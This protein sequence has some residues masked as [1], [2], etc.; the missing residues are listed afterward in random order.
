ML[1]FGLKGKDKIQLEGTD[2]FY[3]GWGRDNGDY[4]HLY[5]YDLEDNLLQDEI[6]TTADVTISSENTVDMDVGQH[7]R[8]LGYTDGEYKV[9]YLF[10]RKTAGDSKRT[11]LLNQEGYIHVGK[12]TTRKV[13]GKTKFFT[14]KGTKGE[15]NQTEL[16]LKELKYAIKEISPDR[17]EVK[18]DL[19]KI[20]NI[21]YIKN[22][23]SINKDMVYTPKKNVPNAGQIRFDLTD[24]NVLIFTAG[25]KERGFTDSMV[26]GELVIKGMYTYTKVEFPPTPPPPPRPLPP[27]EKKAIKK[28]LLRKKPLPVREE[29]TEVVDAPDND[30]EDIRGFDDY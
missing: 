27:K 25:N 18:V 19:Q 30:Y 23:K 11:V 8:E 12:T 2:T 22:F 6:L 16:T 21:P 3:T 5:I 20:N 14:N 24:P 7:L 10:L 1:N 4:I 28:T 29:L 15:R 17:K 9:S 26:G 13:N